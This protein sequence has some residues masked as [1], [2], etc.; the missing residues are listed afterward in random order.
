MQVSIAIFT[1]EAVPHN[2]VDTADKYTDL[3]RRDRRRQ[4]L[5]GGPITP[6]KSS[7]CS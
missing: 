5:S 4:C 3:P 2:C 7:I 1:R 6:I